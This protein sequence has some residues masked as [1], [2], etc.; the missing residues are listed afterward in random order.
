MSF[1][2]TINKNTE[3]SHSHGVTLGASSPFSTFSFDAI[4]YPAGVGQMNLTI[5]GN[6]VAVVTYP[7]QYA[8]SA[9][10]KALF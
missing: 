9:K 5:G 6:V 8:G 1:D 7:S 10:K 2:T 4:P 3:R